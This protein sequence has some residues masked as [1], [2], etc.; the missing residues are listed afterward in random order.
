MAINIPNPVRTL[1]DWLAFVE[2][3]ENADRHFELVHGEI[4]EKMPGTTEN[5]RIPIEIAGHI[6]IYC[7]TNKLTYY[8]GGSDGTYLIN[9]HVV[10]PDLAFKT[11]PFTRGYP[12]PVPPTFVVEVVSASETVS[13]IR[14][15]RS[16]YLQAGIL[17]WEIYPEEQ[18]VEIYEPG[19]PMRAVNA[20]GTLDGDGV[21]PGWSIPAAELWQNI[22]P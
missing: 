20:T 6:F 8:L 19:K 5:S 2:R 4:I 7:R 18:V 3:P 12:D 10:A 11:T 15:K 9:E 22:S 13:S 21:L 16:I 14:K 1:T 17:Y